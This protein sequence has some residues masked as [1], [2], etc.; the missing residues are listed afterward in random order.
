MR[1]Q[2]T[3]RTDL[4]LE[5]ADTGD[6]VLPEGV[7]V[8][9]K[10]EDGVRRTLVRIE[11]DGAAERLGRPKGKYLTLEAPL[12]SSDP[13]TDR[14]AEALSELLPDGP[15]L[16]AGLGNRS[17]TPDALGPDTAHAIIATRHIPP[18]QAK[19]VGL[20][21]LR[22]VC[23]IAPGAMGQTGIET[24]DIVAA[25]VRELGFSAVVAVDALAAR[26]ME[27][28]GATIQLSDSGIAP[29]AGVRNQ[30]S[31]LSEASLGI[32]VLA[33]GIPTVVDAATLLSDLA[34]GCAAL[35]GASGLIVTPRDIDTIIDKGARILSV[36]L[37]RALQPTLSP[38]DVTLLMD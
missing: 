20:D 2:P 22:P 32:P 23:S 27:R 7:F 8:E 26:S 35:D 19:A 34:P 5:A 28:L 38:D 33:L 37:N 29:G 9:E 15:V 21:G 10:E 13:L 31:E 16:V 25:L 17:I 14:L 12:S 24:A 18:E 6:G 4:A 36:A 30:R 1:Q 11:S 3:F